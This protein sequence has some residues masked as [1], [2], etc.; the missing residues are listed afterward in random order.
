MEGVLSVGEGVVNPP[1]MM[2]IFIGI[3][4]RITNELCG[5]NP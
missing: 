1:D 3:S 4:K 5:E 2:G